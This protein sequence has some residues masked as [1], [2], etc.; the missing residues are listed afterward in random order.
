MGLAAPAIPAL[1]QRMTCP[2]VEE[3]GGLPASF[4]EI[5]FAGN[6]RKFLYQL[7]KTR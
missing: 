7:N 4:W 2:R 3:S 5:L 6:I 1:R